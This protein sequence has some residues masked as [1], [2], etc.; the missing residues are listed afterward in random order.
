[1]NSKS[2][3][4][5]EIYVH[6]ELLQDF[7]NIIKNMTRQQAGE[8]YARYIN[9]IDDAMEDP[10]RPNTKLEFDLSSFSRLDFFSMR[11]PP[12]GMSPNYRFLYRYDSHNFKF[13]KFAVGP[14]NAKGINGDSIYYIAKHRPK[15]PE[16]WRRE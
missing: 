6:P 3:R 11:K 9:V 8:F 16:V 12:R 10:C 1:M 15:T 4:I 5:N 13:Y 14:R 7:I 2:Y